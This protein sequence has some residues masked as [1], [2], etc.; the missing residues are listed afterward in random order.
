M[1]TLTAGTVSRDGLV[2]DLATPEADGDEFANDGTKVVLVK[3]D[4]V[5][6]LSVTIT[7]HATLDGQA[8]DDRVVQIDPG[9]MVLIGP[10][11]TSIYNH[12]TTGRVHVEIDNRTDVLIGVVKQVIA[13]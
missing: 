10:F 7:T 13:N 12:P 8:V 6:Y 11:P 5:N 1:A 4:S 3:N 9:D 2:L